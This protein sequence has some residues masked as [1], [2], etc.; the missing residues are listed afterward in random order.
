MSAP[1][2]DRRP[3]VPRAP[4]LWIAG[5]EDTCVY[6]PDRFAMAPLDEHDLTEHT[7]RWRDDLDA[8]LDLGVTALRYG[9]RWPLVH[10]APGVFDWAELDERLAYATGLGL[11]VIADLV[12][13]GTPTWLDGSFADPRYVDAIAEFSA[14]F[15]TRYAGIVDH[16]TPLNEPLTT[17]S[18]AG[19]RGVWPPA[20]TGWGGWTTVTLAIAEGITAATEAIRAANPDAVIVHVEAGT[21]VSTQDAALDDHARLLRDLGWLPTD[22]MLGRVGEDHPM[23]SWMRDHGAPE[24]RL[25]RLHNEPARIDVLGVNYYPDLTPRTLVLR[26]GTVVQDAHDLWTSGLRAVVVGFAERYGLPIIVTETSIEGTDDV[27][28]DWVTDSAEALRELADEGIDV[29]GSTWWPV[30]DFVDWSYASGGRNVEEFGVPDDVVAERRAAA[31]SGAKT[32]YLRRMGL[33]RLEEQSDGSLERVETA[34]A[35]RFRAITATTV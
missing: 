1:T 12:H 7:E 18:F 16:L 33:I 19:L 25:R 27:R 17:A 2:A 29:R 22:L 26:Q 34:A 20:L 14:A 35:T 21:L 28:A 13:Y 4:F 23:W 5:I 8:V 15:A 6:P 10:L 9:V 31:A 32:P 11:T 24:D 3:E 30:F